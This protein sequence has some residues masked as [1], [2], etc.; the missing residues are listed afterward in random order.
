M[1]FPASERLVFGRKLLCYQRR[2]KQQ[3]EENPKVNK[4]SELKELKAISSEDNQ[5]GFWSSIKESPAKSECVRYQQDEANSKYT[6][7]HSYYMLNL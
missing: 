2:V 6:L 1:Q 4:C 3:Q 5:Y 7:L